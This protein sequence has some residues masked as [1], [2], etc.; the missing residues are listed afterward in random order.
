MPAPVLQS[1]TTPDAGQE[2]DRGTGSR[3]AVMM[4][5]ETETLLSLEFVRGVDQAAREAFLRCTP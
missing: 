5:P 2:L 4:D 3:V 1:M